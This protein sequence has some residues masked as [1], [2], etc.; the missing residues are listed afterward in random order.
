[1]TIISEATQLSLEQLRNFQQAFDADPKNRL[2]LNAITKNPVHSVVLN[3][4]I[5]TGTDH[6][7]S[8]MLKSNESTSQARSGRCWL[9]AGLNLFRVEAIKNL[10]IEKF[11]LSQNYL[12]FWDKLEKANYFLESIMAA[13]DEPVNG[14]LI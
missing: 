4:N 6:T 5:V 3:H 9:F 7:F 12:M 8:Y 2:A 14:R 13:L 11:E 1:M 10:N